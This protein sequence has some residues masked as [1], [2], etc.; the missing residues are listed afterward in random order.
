MGILIGGEDFSPRSSPVDPM[1][2]WDVSVLGAVEALVLGH[3]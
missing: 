3:N 1:P 2:D